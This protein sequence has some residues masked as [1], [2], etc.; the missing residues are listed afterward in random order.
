MKNIKVTIDISTD[1]VTTTCEYQGKQH[2][3][4]S[5]R[6][7]ESTSFETDD[8]SS[9]QELWGLDLLLDDIVASACDLSDLLKNEDEEDG[10]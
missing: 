10:E 3:V 9:F 2:S 7:E 5:K 8:F 1:E 6:F 4:K